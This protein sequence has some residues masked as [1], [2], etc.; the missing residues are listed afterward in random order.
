MIKNFEELITEVKKTGKKRLS[1]AIPYEVED[2]KA[3]K[4]AKT[5]VLLN[6]F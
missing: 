1:I 2:L 5:K 3:L 4:F 6:Q